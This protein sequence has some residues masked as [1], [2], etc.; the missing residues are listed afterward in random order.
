MSHGRGQEVGG[1]RS[2]AQASRW[3]SDTENPA[4]FLI[5]SPLIP[6]YILGLPSI[7]QQHIIIYYH[8]IIRSCHNA[9]LSHIQASHNTR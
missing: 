5:H 2:K 3:N 1:T 6:N 9:S 4:W 8:C 7:L